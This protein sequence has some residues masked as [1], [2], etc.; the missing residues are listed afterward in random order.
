MIVIQKFMSNKINSYTKNT[1]K[2]LIV[3]SR[4]NVFLRNT[5]EYNVYFLITSILWIFLA[6]FSPLFL[7]GGGGVCIGINKLWQTNHSAP[8]DSVWQQGIYMFKAV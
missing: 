1:V 7:G 5:I 3:A 2:K 8:S 4:W 6:K